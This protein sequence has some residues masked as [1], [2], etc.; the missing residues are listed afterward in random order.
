[1]AS[2][3]VMR[4]KGMPYLGTRLLS[5][6]E[7]AYL[8]REYFGLRSHWILLRPLEGKRLRRVHP[9]WYG[10]LRLPLIGTLLKWVAPM[11]EIVAVRP[12]K[13]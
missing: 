1:L 10:A 4:C 7:L 11:Y 9:L 2:W 13:E 12:E 8:L 6:R 3:Y 5:Y